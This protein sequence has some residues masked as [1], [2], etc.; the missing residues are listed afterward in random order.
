MEPMMSVSLKIEG[1]EFYNSNDVKEVL[2]GSNA[3]IIDSG[4]CSPEPTTI[5]D[6]SNDEVLVFRNGN[7]G[8]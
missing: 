7:G 3:L 1:Y 8:L 6:L 5:I 4:H 2:H